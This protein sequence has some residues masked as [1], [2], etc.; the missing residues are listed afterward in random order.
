MRTSSYECET[1]LTPCPLVAEL[2]QVIHSILT[3]R[4]LQLPLILKESQKIACMLWG[5]AI[6]L[7]SNLI[8]GNTN[9]RAS[10]DPIIYVIAL[11]LLKKLEQ[12]SC[13]ILSSRSNNSHMTYSQVGQYKF[14]FGGSLLFSRGLIVSLCKTTRL[15]V[16]KYKPLSNTLHYF[17]V[18][19]SGLSILDF[20]DCIAS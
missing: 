10:S 5:T 16:N 3:E 14:F 8:L 2:L 11:T 1:I 7:V 4:H 6:S 20:I 13:E 15:H 12:E 18:T 9:I 17:S 19:N